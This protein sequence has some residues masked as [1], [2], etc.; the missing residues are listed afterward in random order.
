MKFKQMLSPIHI[1]LIK[2]PPI[3]IT[4]TKKLYFCASLVLVSIFT[5]R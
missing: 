2:F 5:I 1:L 4:E 3:S